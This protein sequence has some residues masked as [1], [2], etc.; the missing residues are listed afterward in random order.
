MSPDQTDRRNPL[1]VETPYP[2]YESTS[3]AYWRDLR[4]AKRFGSSR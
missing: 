1:H 3:Q 4:H 2:R